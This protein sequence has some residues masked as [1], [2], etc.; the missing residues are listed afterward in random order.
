MKIVKIISFICVLALAASMCSMFSFA[1]APEAEVEVAESRATS[2]Y[3]V[4]YKVNQTRTYLYNRP[5]PTSGYVRPAPFSV[6]TPVYVDPSYIS[7]DY[8]KAKVTDGGVTYYGYF[9]RSHLSVW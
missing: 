7:D 1:A 6:D 2:G 4:K 5:S 9:E 8:Y 3:T